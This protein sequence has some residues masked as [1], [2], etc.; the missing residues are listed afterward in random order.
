MIPQ[1]VDNYLCILA[2]QHFQTGSNQKFV[3]VGVDMDSLLPQ[4]GYWVD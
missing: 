4:E 2:H 1:A 3:Q